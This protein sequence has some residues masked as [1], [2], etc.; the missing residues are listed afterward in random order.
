MNDVTAHDLTAIRA[1]LERAEARLRRISLV[2]LGTVAAAVIGVSVGFATSALAGPP[3]S[4][5]ACDGSRSSWYCFSQGE[6][7]RASEINSNFEQLQR[8]ADD[9]YNTRL[10][11]SGGTLNGSLNVTGGLSVGAGLPIGVSG[12]YYAGWGSDYARNM[13]S[14]SRRV[15]F[16][17]NVDTAYLAGD[18]RVSCRV[19]T[20]GGSWMLN[21]HKYFG[22]TAEIRCEA[23]CITW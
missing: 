12:S 13:G 3:G 1:R 19:S 14:T 20:S 17:T 22:S 6:P 15:C 2:A 10:P 16:L 18:S 21:A 4:P 5:F 23:Q 9:L 7:A 8:R 11:T